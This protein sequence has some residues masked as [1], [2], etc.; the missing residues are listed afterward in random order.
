M[1]SFRLFELLNNISSQI[2]GNDKPFGGIKLIFVGDFCQIPPARNIY[3][4]GK[5]CFESPLW[6]VCFPLTHSFYFT[7][8]FGQDDPEFIK[9]LNEAR[10]GNL[11]ETSKAY[12]RSLGCHII[13]VVG[14]ESFPDH[15][16]VLSAH[17]MDCFI[18]N[19]DKLHEDDKEE[20]IVIRSTDSGTFSS[21]A[22]DQMLQVP[23][24]L[25]LKKGCHVMAVRNIDDDLRNGTVG[26]VESFLNNEFPV[27]S[28]P[29]SGKVIVMKKQYQ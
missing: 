19:R 5:Y 3:E 6:F 26:I 16:P 10:V 18:I 11:S 15:I 8:I 9:V 25:T 7:F 14:D 22:L 29:E 13:K 4:D 2:R 27:V 12:L 28:F 1:L 23:H 20:I 24:M 21:I 17:R